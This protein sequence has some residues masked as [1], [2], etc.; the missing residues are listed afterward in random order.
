MK[1]MEGKEY[2][3]PKFGRIQVLRQPNYKA[4]GPR[5]VLIRLKN[6]IETIVPQ[7]SL[8]KIKEGIKA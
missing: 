4:G 7:R 5:N 2:N 1:N 3:H 8:R 6:G